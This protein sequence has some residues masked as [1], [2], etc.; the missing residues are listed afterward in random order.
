MPVLLL[1]GLLLGSSFFQF[2]REVLAETVTGPNASATASESAS[3][4]EAGGEGSDDRTGSAAVSA[5]LEEAASTSSN[6]VKEEILINSEEDFLK[7]S[8]GSLNESATIGKVFRLTRDLDFREKEFRPISVFSGILEGDGH[9][10]EG[11]RLHG[12]FSR[13]G[14]I[15]MV[16]ESGVVRNLS[17][18]G[19]IIW[20]NEDEEPNGIINLALRFVSDNYDEQNTRREIGGIAGENWGR[21]ENCS[22][23]GSVSAYESVGGIVG[24]NRVTGVISSC[25]NQALVNGMKKAGGIV[26]L[27]EGTVDSCRNEGSVNTRVR[28]QLQFFT[29]G[30]EEDLVSFGQTGM[31]FLTNPFSSLFQNSSGSLISALKGK[32]V[33]AAGGIAGENQGL[34]ANNVNE[35]RVGLL[36]EG[37]EVGG[38][39]GYEKGFSR[40]NRNS[41]L[42]RGRKDVGGIAGIFEPYLQDTYIRDAFDDARNNLDNLVALITSLHESLKTEDDKTQGLID[43]IR[44]EMDV[45]RGKI[46]SYK[47][48]FRGKDD[49]TEKAIRYYVDIIRGRTDELDIDGDGDA[50]KALK[51]LRNDVD[52]L[53]KTVSATEEAFG[54][55]IAVDMTNYMTKGMGLL[56][57]TFTQTDVLLKASLEDG[58]ELEDFGDQLKVVRGAIGDLY[59]YLQGMVD[60]Y[61][62]DIRGMDDDISASV[63]AIYDGIAGIL[64]SLKGSDSVLRERL[65][66]LTDEMQ[67]LN[68]TMNRAWDQV[69]EELERIRGKVGSL[70]LTVVFDDISDDGTLEG[71]RGILY[72]NL[73]EGDIEADYNG[74]GIAGTM[75][76]LTDEADDLDIDRTGSFSL[77]FSR[78]QRASVISCRNSGKV[79]VTHDYAGGIV[80]RLE[81]GAVLQSESHGDVSAEG[82]YAGGVAGKSGYVL[83]DNKAYGSIRGRNYVGGIA[84]LGSEVY[85]NMAGTEVTGEDRIGYIV[86]ELDED[87]RMEGNEAIRSGTE[88]A[89]E[90]P[91]AGNGPDGSDAAGGSPVT[92]D[93]LSV[94]GNVVTVPDKLKDKISLSSNIGIGG[95]D[96]D[97]SKDRASIQENLA[98]NAEYTISS[99]EELPKLLVTGS[100]PVDAELNYEEKEFSQDR[101]EV[102]AGGENSEEEYSAVG[103]YG[104]HISGKSPSEKGAVTVRFLMDEYE[105]GD[106]IAKEGEKGP[107]LVSSVKDGRYRVFSMPEQEGGFYIVRPKT[108]SLK[109]I[110]LI[111]GIIV[112]ILI[113]MLAIILYIKRKPRQNGGSL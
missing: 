8:A 97:S 48:Y 93:N 57:D 46:K 88:S 79:S 92:P 107:E 103:H 80:G 109:T 68:R 28:S 105:D 24:R 4:Q 36:H 95:E 62:A 104:Y 37:Y 56:E 86:G 40:E 101:T 108:N 43:G 61:K 19:N 90:V 35:G 1:S 54:S 65:T 113:V 22:F 50:K 73:N 31:E 44:G 59:T 20:I 47:E 10:I 89:N 77:K 17:A 23:A 32:R 67:A 74:G 63:T 16:G 69:K 83:R 33:L 3:E 82:D 34:V 78:T 25:Q 110:L 30:E 53:S 13:S 85:G 7:L 14:L 87:G 70:D 42:I 72:N 12:V 26:G 9:R 94:S 27:N 102:L 76:V 84:G 60:S 58:D 6:A 52:V 49:E 39:V 11:F 41:A 66:S 106:L 99:G 64:D 112:G 55:G 96:K 75:E 5:P 15:R 38:I 51:A 29:E 21:I 71:D 18:E 45:L 98:D 111:A 81:R 100:I 2:H 91:D